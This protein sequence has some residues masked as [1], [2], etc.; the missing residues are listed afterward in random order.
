MDTATSIPRTP[1]LKAGT[2][3]CGVKYYVL[4]N[5][6]KPTD[7]VELRLIVKVGSL[8][9]E[10]GEQGLAHF[11]EHLGFKGTE[12]FAKYEIVRFLQSLGISYGADLNASTHLL[13]TTFQL[14]TDVND[15]LTNFQHAVSILKEWAFHMRID[16]HDVTEEKSVINAEYVAKQGL[17]ERLL[18]KYWTAVFDDPSNP[19]CRLAKRMPIGIPE[20][21][22]NTNA[23]QIRE[24][25]EK[26]YTT[27]NMAVVVV[28]DFQGDEERVSGVV[29]VLVD[30][31]KSVPLRSRGN[32]LTCGASTTTDVAAA[33]TTAAA[34]A[35]AVAATIGTTTTATTT[36]TAAAVPKPYLQLPTHHSRDTYVALSD[37]ELSV[38]QISFEFFSPCPASSTTGYLREDIIRRLICSVY[39][40]RL[41]SIASGQCPFYAGSPPFI[42]AG[43]SIRQI[44]RGLQCFGL[45]A[46]L[47][48][49]GS[50][51]SDTEV[52]KA[53]RAMGSLLTEMKRFSMHGATE[54]EF[55]AAKNKWEM[56]FSDQR[57]HTMPDAKAITADLVN[58]IL[59]N[60]NTIFQVK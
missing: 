52:M 56:L 49:E 11:I 33:A 55:S 59:C 58:H 1:H 2:L 27:D 3:A 31:F 32:S 43:I 39:D 4:G 30:V 38:A 19:D 57:D 14:S 21:F 13:E 22:M 7:S 26:W 6:E 37:K 25:Y 15:G 60:E 29:S 16:E 24:F 51:D 23:K 53:R 18:K 47:D 42:S 10:Q 45:T 40:R 54:D 20:V 41:H 28:G 46:T 35:A 8:M 44:V 34:T 12:N 36:T 17:S 5:A 9:E 48:S 50:E